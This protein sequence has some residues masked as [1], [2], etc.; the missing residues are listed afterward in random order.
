MSGEPDLD[1]L[2]T[3]LLN[4]RHSG[5][6]QRLTSEAAA[7]RTRL[8]SNRTLPKSNAR[9]RPTL[10]PPDVSEDALASA[11]KELR[12]SIGAENVVV[13]DQPLED[14]WYLE[15]PN[16]HDAFHVVEQEEL[17]CSVVT[18]PG[19]TAEVQTVVRWANKHLIPIY[20]ISIGRNVGY[21]GAA[22]RVPGG[23]VVDLGKRMHSI[24]NVDGGNASCVVE[25]SVTYFG[26]Y[27]EIQ[28]RGLPLWIDCPDLG[29]G[30]LLGNAIDRGVGYTPAG[31]HFANHCGMEIV[32]PTGELLRTSMVA[33]PGKDGEDNA[34]WQSFQNAYG[35]QVDGIFSQSNFGIVTKIG[36]WLVH[37]M[38]H[39]SYCITFANDEDF[40]E[41]VDTIGLLAQTG[42]LGNV[43]QLRH[44]MQE[45]NVT[46]KR[47]SAFHSGS[48]PMTR[49][50]I[51]TAAKDLPLGDCSW[52]FYGTQYGDPDSIKRQL[53][54]I[55]EAF[56][57]IP[58]DKFWLPKDVPDDH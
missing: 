21:G 36:F 11:V 51:R 6:P 53:N 23:V 25:P 50:E 15:H 10:L 5:V 52:I 39:Q 56:S 55:Q 7:A 16:T 32:L 49:E 24:V 28:R 57:K 41:I 26:L 30:S 48:G 44:I 45:L 18:Y 4:D 33:L 38:P 47:K 31:D 13:N 54:L 8:Y 42:V 12:Q 14:V 17:V 27:E 34:T 2:P 37:D 19:S 58:G 35:P 1:L 29:G 46:G 9:L 20:P 22:P 40:T 3:P 43:P